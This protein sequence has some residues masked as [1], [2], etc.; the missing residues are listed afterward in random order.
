MSLSALLLVLVS[1][2]AL[3]LT[4]LIY[5]LPGFIAYRRDHPNRL[6]ILLLN[7]LLGGTGIVWIICLIWALTNPVPPAPRD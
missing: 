5:L 6:V 2:I 3:V 4:L 7:I 1:I